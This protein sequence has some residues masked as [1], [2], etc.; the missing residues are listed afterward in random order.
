MD[1]RPWADGAGAVH[2]GLVDQLHLQVDALG[3]GLVQPGADLVGRAAGAHAAADDEDVDLFF[4]DLGIA[5][6]PAMSCASGNLR[7][8][9]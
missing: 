2:G 6:S 9:V 8:S 5:E 3:L 7:R 4:D 1:D